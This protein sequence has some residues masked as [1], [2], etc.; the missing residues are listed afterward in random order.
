[1][2]HNEVVITVAIFMLHTLC[3]LNSVFIVLLLF[4]NWSVYLDY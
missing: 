2:I 3:K 1:M 4:V